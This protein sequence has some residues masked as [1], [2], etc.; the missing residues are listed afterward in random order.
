VR[1]RQQQDDARRA[2]QQLLALFAVL[3]LA[4]VV[5]VNGLLL[6]LWWVI[7]SWLSLG[8]PP[9]FIETNTAVVLLFVLGGA[10][11]ELGRLRSGGGLHVAEWAGGRLL[12]NPR[13]A[14]ERVKTR[15][16]PLPLAGCPRPRSSR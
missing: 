9:L 16:T 6:G 14:T 3:L 7:G 2:T 1:F 13:D 8:L 12:T 11:V 4:L 5:A 15:S 10:W